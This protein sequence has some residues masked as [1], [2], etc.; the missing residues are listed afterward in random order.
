MSS[1]TQKGLPAPR[2]HRSSKWVAVSGQEAREREHE[3]YHH[4]LV[5]RVH[6]CPWLLWAEGLCDSG[7]LWW[8]LF[9][10]CLAVVV[11]TVEMPASSAEVF[12]ARRLAELLA[13]CVRWTPSLAARLSAKRQVIPLRVNPRRMPRIFELW[14]TRWCSAAVNPSALPARSAT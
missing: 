11:G 14:F 5:V 6:T 4:L 7:Q 13:A 12:C 1:W 10:T 8:I 2:H 9:Y 3:V